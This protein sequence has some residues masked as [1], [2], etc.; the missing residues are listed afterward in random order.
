LQQDKRR[1][2]D[3]T[4]AVFVADVIKCLEKSLE[5]VLHMGNGSATIMVASNYS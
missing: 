5:K 1:P 2:Q 4:P 3:F